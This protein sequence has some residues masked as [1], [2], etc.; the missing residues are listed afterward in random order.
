MRE[1]L[2]L[3]PRVS[4]QA[5]M[6][7][8][9]RNPKRVFEF[10]ALIHVIGLAIVLSPLSFPYTGYESA[11]PAP[12]RVYI[13]QVQRQFFFNEKNLSS[14]KNEQ[15]LYYNDSGLWFLNMDRNSP[16][17]LLNEIP[18]LVEAKH[19]SAD[20]YKNLTCGLPTYSPRWLAMWY[21]GYRQGH[22]WLTSNFFSNL[23]WY[24]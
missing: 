19:M 17:A 4:F 20:C 16:S 22:K 7:P 14:G 18:A 1:F 11:S 3:N 24:Y 15:K 6:V 12:Q 10:L 9:V 2:T 23:C 5:P 21:V 8:L 13:F